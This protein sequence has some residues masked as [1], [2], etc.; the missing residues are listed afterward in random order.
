M[1]TYGGHDDSL[2]TPSI[3]WFAPYSASVYKHWTNFKA[4]VRK[5]TCLDGRAMEFCPDCA[6]QNRPR[7]GHSETPETG[8]VLKDVE[9]VGTRHTLDQKRRR[10]RQ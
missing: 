10:Q 9:R 4:S 6:V 8:Q 1:F 2:E 5:Y 3:S 7:R